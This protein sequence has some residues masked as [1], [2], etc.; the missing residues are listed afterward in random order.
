MKLSYIVALRLGNDR[1]EWIPEIVL[2]TFMQSFDIES[3]IGIGTGTESND[4]CGL[5]GKNSEAES[6]KEEAIPTKAIAIKQLSTV[7]TNTS[8]VSTSAN[9]N[10]DG[11]LIKPEFLCYSASSRL[12]P[13]APTVSVARTMY[14]ESK[15]QSTA[16]HAYACLSGK[17]LQRAPSSRSVSG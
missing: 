5:S 6:T 4:F 12:R 17:K 2:Y 11:N 8:E 7:P 15:C 10:F 13:G 1:K 9:R 3:L 14:P 16:L